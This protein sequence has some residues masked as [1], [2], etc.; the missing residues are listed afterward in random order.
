MSDGTPELVWSTLAVEDLRAAR[1]YVAEAGDPT[2]ARALA[3]RIRHRV[4]E[5]PR[6]PHIG[7][8]VP[9]FATARLREVI[10]APYRIVYLVDDAAPRL[11]IVRIWHGRRDLPRIDPHEA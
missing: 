2:A 6:H 5:L 8:V 3:N 10:V 11:V 4:E 1:E 7:R 9:E